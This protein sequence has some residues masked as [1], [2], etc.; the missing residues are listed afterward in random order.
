MGQGLSNY[1]KKTGIGVDNHLEENLA[2]LSVGDNDPQMESDIPINKKTLNKSIMKMDAIVEDAINSKKE[3]LNLLSSQKET[4]PDT[5]SLTNY[6][7]QFTNTDEP[8]RRPNGDDD[9]DENQIQGND[10]DDNTPTDPEMIPI[11][12]KSSIYGTDNLMQFGP[13]PEPELIQIQGKSSIYGTTSNNLILF[14][15][16]HHPDEIEFIPI[17]KKSSIYGTNQKNLSF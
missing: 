13:Q 17:E 2:N 7:N 8:K 10:E 4:P 14:G 12:G 16:K 1:Q 15:E 5:G 6:L 9:D 11:Q 3:L